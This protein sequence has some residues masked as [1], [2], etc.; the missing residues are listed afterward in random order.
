MALAP[1]LSFAQGSWDIIDVPTDRH[2][3]SVYFTDSLYGWAVGDTGTIIHTNDGGETWIVQDAGTNN[4]IV[5]VFFLN[6]QM[7][8]ASSWNFEGFFGTL[9]LKTIDGGSSWTS[10]SYQEDNIFMNSILFLDSL[11]G[12]MG[13]S[14]HA[15]VKTT[16]GGQSWTQSAIDTNALAF[17]PVLNIYFYDDNYGYACGGMFDIAGVTWRTNNGGENWYEIEVSDA[18]ADEVHELYIFDSLK[19]LGAGGDPDFGY[20]IGML[21]TTDGGFNWDYDEIG[22]QGNAFDIDFVNENEVWAPLG[23]QRKF[24]YS[25]D[26]GSTWMQIPTTDLT[27]IY[28]VMFPD[29]YLS[30]CR[31]RQVA[32]SL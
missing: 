27:A 32:T 4:G 25:I 18:P 22:I 2:L 15:I 19:V 1:L 28:D 12:W 26:T 31:F 16:D 23:P 14:P 3:R 8:W 9:I 17:F 10:E 30:Y 11:N 29:S 21:R 20:G 13:G 5:D 7:G 6:R 24:I